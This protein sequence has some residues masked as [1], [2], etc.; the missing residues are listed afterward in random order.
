MADKQELKQA[1][2][3]LGATEMKGRFLYDSFQRKD[4]SVTEEILES[5]SDFRERQ[6]REV[7]LLRQSVPGTEGK[8]YWW[9]LPYDIRKPPGLFAGTFSMPEGIYS[10]QEDFEEGFGL[11]LKKAD[12]HWLASDILEMYFTGGDDVVL[13][14]DRKR[15]K[16]KL[17]SEAAIRAILCAEEELPVRQQEE[18][19]TEPGAFDPERSRQYRRMA[20]EL[21]FLSGSL[22]GELERMER[23]FDS[24]ERFVHSSMFTNRE[25]MEMGQMSYTDY[26]KAEFY[27]NWAL[28]QKEAKERKRREE[29]ESRM[30]AM[31]WEDVKA[32]AARKSGEMKRALAR[33]MKDICMRLMRCGYAFYLEGRLAGI[34]IFKGPVPVFQ[35]RHTGDISPYD[36]FGKIGDMR[37]L[38]YQTPDPAPLIRFILRQYGAQMKP[39]SVLSPRPKNASDEL[40]RYWAEQRLLQR[41]LSGD[42]GTEKQI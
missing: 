8:S 12:S 31:W 17:S 4:P 2:L 33:N 24:W 10:E 34:V 39:Y 41:I 20:E 26:A 3:L 30:Y 28:S 29:L 22:P 23:S 18:Y 27:R 9:D 16:E 40:W 6:C 19:S 1:A 42:T 37:E 7:N 11:Y 32:D 36:I 13:Y 21:R 5:L 25:R 14:A 35:I 38:E 15:M